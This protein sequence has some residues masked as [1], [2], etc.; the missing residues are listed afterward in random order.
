MLTAGKLPQSV[1]PSAPR[2]PVTKLWEI[3]NQWYAV[4]GQLCLLG[5]VGGSQT[6]RICYLTCWVSLSC[7]YISD[8]QH[9]HIC[10]FFSIIYLPLFMFLL[11]SKHRK[12]D[13]SGRFSPLSL[14]VI[15]QNYNWSAIS[16]AYSH[17]FP[18]TFVLMLLTCIV[19][20][21]T[22]YLL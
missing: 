22:H 14:S 19:P 18:V 7:V 17:S 6:Q 9:L 15:Q 16:N 8:F 11:S 13:R 3:K 5:I 1:T 4:Y 10:R 21:D 20:F 12:Y 2:C